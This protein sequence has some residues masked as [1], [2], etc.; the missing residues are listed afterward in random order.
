MR[1]NFWVQ[2]SEPEHYDLVLNIRRVG[3]DECVDQIIGLVDSAEFAET[4]ESRQRLADVALAWRARGGLALAHSV[5][6][7]ELRN[8]VNAVCAGLAGVSE[9][10]D[11]LLGS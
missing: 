3:I 10:D 1:R 9:I 2:W 6:T 8:A 5:E 4:E 11:P 7:A